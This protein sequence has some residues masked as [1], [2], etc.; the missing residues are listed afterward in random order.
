VTT[1]RRNLDILIAWL[2]AGRRADRAAMLALLAPDAEWQGIRPEWRCDTPDTVVA[3]WLERSAE[4]DDAEGFDATADP[5]GAS[6]HLRAP[7][8]A[9]LD[10]RLRRGVHIRFAVGEDGR[11]TRISDH[12][13]K[14]DAAPIVAAETPRGVPEAPLEHGRPTEE[15]WYVVNLADARWET[16]R[17]G[18]YTLLEGETRWPQVGVNVG[19]L[20]PGQAACFYHRE[21]DQEDF[22]VL[23]GEALL[24]V[25][26]EERRLRAW[27]FVHCPA[28]TEHVFVGAGDGPSTIL[29]IGARSDGGGVYPVGEVALRHG[30]GVEREAT[31]SR[32]AYAGIPPDEP[33]AFDPRWLPGDRGE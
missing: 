14:R 30:A 12:A 18:A 21:A 19:V 7:A 31:L 33:V 23:G 24:L 5:R 32:D 22:L 11:I 29:A 16:G 28:W 6:L 25:E 9:Q 4:L 27:D 10:D 20:E 1:R 17:F 13:S 26:G 2:D 15:G 8:L 3:M